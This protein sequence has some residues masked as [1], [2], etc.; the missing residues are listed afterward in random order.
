MKI[1][2]YGPKC[3]LFAKSIDGKQLCAFTLKKKVI[4]MQHA[5]ERML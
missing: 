3:N 5:Q 4:K 1:I 2:T